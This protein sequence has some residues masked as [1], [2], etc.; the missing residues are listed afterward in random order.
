MSFR[1]HERE[2]IISDFADT[3]NLTN[4]LTIGSIYELGIQWNIMVK[5]TIIILKLLEADACNLNARVSRGGSSL[6]MHIMHKHLLVVSKS[7]LDVT[8]VQGDIS[9][10]VLAIAGRCEYNSIGNAHPR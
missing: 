8:M 10:I 7:I 2:C 4:V 5:S 9:A 6:R 3:L 1:G